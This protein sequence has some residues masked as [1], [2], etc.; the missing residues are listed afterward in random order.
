MYSSS[1][2][3]RCRK[4]RFGVWLSISRITRKVPESRYSSVKAGVFRVCQGHL[5]L[6]NTVSGAA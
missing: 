4:A 1:S 5:R 3:G 6:G 2:R